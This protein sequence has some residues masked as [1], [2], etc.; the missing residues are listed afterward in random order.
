MKTSHKT[1]VP[2]S[3]WSDHLYN[4]QPLY[5]TNDC[6]SLDAVASI[7]WRRSM[8]ELLSNSVKCHIHI[9]IALPSKALESY[10]SLRLRLLPSILVLGQ[11]SMMYVVTFLLA[12]PFITTSWVVLSLNMA[13]HNT[14]TL[15]C[16]V[17]VGMCGKRMTRGW[18]IHLFL[19]APSNDSL[20]YEVFSYYYFEC[21]VQHDSKTTVFHLF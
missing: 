11:W 21:Q 3:V 8:I 9:P 6:A 19:L 16:R 7:R 12:H 5:T 20:F 13:T 2:Y 10:K 14:F 18:H 15:Q 17:E 1:W 4:M